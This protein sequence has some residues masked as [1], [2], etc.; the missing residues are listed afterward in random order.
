MPIEI[1]QKKLRRAY[2]ISTVWFMLY[3][4]VL[5]FPIGNLTTKMLSGNI[6]IINLVMNITAIV[7]WAFFIKLTIKR[8]RRILWAF[9]SYYYQNDK[10]QLWSWRIP[11]ENAR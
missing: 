4:S 9:D 5:A 1:D 8:Y 11:I 3:I 2:I 6:D 7:F 10:L